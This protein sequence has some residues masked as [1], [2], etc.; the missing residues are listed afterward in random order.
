MLTTNK[1]SK[2]I[3]LNDIPHETTTWDDRNPP[4][5]NNEVKE[6]MHDKNQ[7]YN[8]YRQNKNNT[9]SLH[10]L[11]FL[12]LNS[13]IEKSKLNYYARLSKKLLYSMTNRNPNGLY[14]KHP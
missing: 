2:N 4:W 8:S 11:E 6:L 10:Q 13:L 3:I 5:I 1:T 9:F 14:E 7:A 12:Q